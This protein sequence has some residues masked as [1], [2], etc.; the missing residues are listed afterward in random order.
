L[1]GGKG[2]WAKLEGGK[3]KTPLK[4]GKERQFR[5]LSRVGEEEGTAEREHACEPKHPENSFLEGEGKGKLDAK[6]G[7]EIPGKPLGRVKS[8]RVDLGG[9]KG[10][11]LYAMI[12]LLT[13]KKTA[14]EKGKG[15]FGC[16]SRGGTSC[17]GG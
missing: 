12:R 14:R 11:N 3:L 5:V 9:R 6:K 4:K 10:Q 13:G 8:G 7:G 15:I 2:V 1:S 17:P 16:G